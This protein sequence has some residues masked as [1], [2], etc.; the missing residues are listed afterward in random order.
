MSLIS[1]YISLCVYV[2]FFSLN[3]FPHEF[4]TMTTVFDPCFNKFI[5][6]KRGFGHSQAI[7]FITYLGH[8]FTY[9][10]D[11]ERLDVRD[12]PP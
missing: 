11:L 3:Y 8:T 12:A 6:R 5:T 2:S 1:V 4:V 10:N 9:H 7:V